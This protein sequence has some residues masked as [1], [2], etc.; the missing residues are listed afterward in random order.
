[1]LIQSTKKLLD[2]IN[3]KPD[4]RPEENPL[5]CWHANLITVNQKKA[6]VL[7]ND[8]N[9]YV[10][11][12][13]GLNAT[14]FENLDVHI[15]NTI[16]ETLKKEQIKDEVIEKY[17]NQEIVYSKT[18]SRSIISKLNHICKVLPEHEE[19]TE[20]TAIYKSDLGVKLSKQIVS[21]GKDGNMTPNEEMHKDLETYI[22]GP[23]F[24]DKLSAEKSPTEKFS[25]VEGSHKG[26]KKKKIG[27]NDP[28]PC[29]SGKKYKKCCLGKEY[30]KCV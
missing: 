18:S 29:G 22:G 2:E 21:N 28:C 14:D 8:K 12:L 27:R 11:V 6:V 23:I 9:N 7:I 25:V 13:Y 26:K 10:N 3:I 30:T 5:F 1:M 17:L 24:A 15:L 4:E 19:L 20:G 16:R